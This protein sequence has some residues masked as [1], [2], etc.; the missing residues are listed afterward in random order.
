[1]TADA[2]Y[3][4]YDPAE[5]Y[6]REERKARKP[7]KC[8]E[9][10]RKIAPG[11]RYEHV[12][13]KWCGEVDTC[14]TCQRCLVLRKWVQA[15]VPCFCWHFGNMR[16]DARETISEYAHECPG[17]WFGWGRREVAIRRAPRV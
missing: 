16:E 2:C 9:C 4:D 8:G 5:F 15:H 3:C 13:G 14:R 10:G 7:Q 6:H 12:R 17:L 11:E 1:M